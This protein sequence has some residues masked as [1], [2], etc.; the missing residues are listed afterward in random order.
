L[1]KNQFNMNNSS[2]TF[3]LIGDPAPAFT[4]QSTQGTIN[5][6]DDFKGNWVVFFSHPADFTPVC[7]TEFMAFQD[8]N[9]EFEARNTKLVGFS[10]DGVHSHI[11]WVRNIERNFGIKIQ[12]PLL[13]GHHIAQM[14]GMI[15]P[16]ADSMATVRAVFIIAPQG[17]VATIMYYPMSN[18]R[19]VFE[20]L[21][22]I[23]SLQLTYNFQ[24]A[25]PA[26]WPHNRIFKDKVIVPPA[27]TLEAAGNIASSHADAKDWYIATE[28]NPI[29]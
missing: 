10:V 9:K 21:R 1:C 12:F 2:S 17:T 18:G 28:E 25:T 23:D 16:N 29:K 24:R 13:A 14:Y 4:A 3:P 5:F 7:T 15:H 6:P 8:L 19:N 11:E 22:M 20:I 26:N 27:N